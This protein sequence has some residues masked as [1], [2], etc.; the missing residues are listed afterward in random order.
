MLEEPLD[1]VVDELV[2]PI[3][4]H[5]PHH[6]TRRMAHALRFGA[7]CLQ[8]AQLLDDLVQQHHD[9]AAGEEAIEGVG[10]FDKGGCVRDV[11]RAG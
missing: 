2:A 4:E 6:Q 1:A 7:R 5:L 3:L 9:V 11:H 10:V 8:P